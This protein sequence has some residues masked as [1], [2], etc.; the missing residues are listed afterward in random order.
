MFWKKIIFS[1]KNKNN[2]FLCIKYQNIYSRLELCQNLSIKCEYFLW[3][4]IPECHVISEI[5]LTR[6]II[7]M[8]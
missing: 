4:R 5:A 6:N 1:T 3:K 7:E 8:G 2:I